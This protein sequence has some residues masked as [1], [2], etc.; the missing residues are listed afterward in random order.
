MTTR[1]VYLVSVGEQDPGFVGAILV[2]RDQAR[3]PVL[4]DALH[5]A[6]KSSDMPLA[7]FAVHCRQ[8]QAVLGVERHM[9]PVVAAT[10]VKS[11]VTV[12]FFFEDE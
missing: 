11:R 1:H 7:P 12:V 5:V 3:Y 10:G 8:H 6:Q 4:H 9:V 2:G